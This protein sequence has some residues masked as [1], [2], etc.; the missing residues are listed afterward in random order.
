MSANPDK[1]KLARSVSR[2]DIVFA[3][4]RVPTSP[5]PM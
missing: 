2:P 1:Q 3:L 5:E 4:A